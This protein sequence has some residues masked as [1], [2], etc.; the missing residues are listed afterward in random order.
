MP[1]YHFRE[2]RTPLFLIGIRF[3]RDEDERL[4]VKYWNKPRKI[5]R[6]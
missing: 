5:W 4:W 2:V 1:Y 3:Y 6:S